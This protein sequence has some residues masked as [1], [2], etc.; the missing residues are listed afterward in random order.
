MFSVVCLVSLALAGTLPYRSAQPA[1]QVFAQNAGG[2]PVA[3]YF[4]RDGKVAPATRVEKPL[5][6]TIF[7]VTLKALLAGPQPDET[8]FGLTSAIRADTRLRGP[9]QVDPTTRT[10]SVDFL[11]GFRSQDATLQARRMAQVVFTLTQFPAITRVT[12]LVNG[13]PLEALNARGR[14]IDGP[15]TRDDYASLTP[16]LLVESPGIWAAVRSP[17]QVSGTMPSDTA[18]VGFRLYDRDDVLLVEGSVGFRRSRNPRRPFQLAVPYDLQTAQRGTLVIFRITADGEEQD[19]VAIPLDLA[20]TAPPPTPTPT[21]TN[22]P[23]PSPTA[24]ATPTATPTPTATATPTITPTPTP[25]ATPSATPTPTPTATPSATPTPSVTPTPT[26]EP[27]STPTPGPS[28]S[29]TFRVLVCPAGMTEDDLDPERCRPVTQG[30]AVRLTGRGL[31]A[32][33]TLEDAQALSQQRFRWT[34]LPYGRY[35]LRLTELPR[36]AD[37]YF[38]RE[39]DLVQGSPEDGYV[40]TIGSGDPDVQFRIYALRV[41]VG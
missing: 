36:G 22:T 33:L 21:P 31:A 19:A 5:S 10:A 32:S 39:S 14:V 9:V 29:I 40:I 18:S 34:D 38:I 35:R 25:T 24:T 17:I 15:A 13:K 6:E 26:P 41:P 28:G 4:F 11:R 7:D 3:V 30:F 37:T 12:F 27:T 20:S 8:A 16:A 23:T 2:V 1:G